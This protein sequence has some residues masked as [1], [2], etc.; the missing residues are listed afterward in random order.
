MPSYK[1]IFHSVIYTNVLINIIV[2][3]KT[4]EILIKAENITHEFLVKKP[5]ASVKV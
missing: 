1:S 4:P 3:Q 2:K 5:C